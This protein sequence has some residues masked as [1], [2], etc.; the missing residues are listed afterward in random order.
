MSGVAG[1]RLLD[2]M[3]RI[4]ISWPRPSL[5]VVLLEGEH[6][7]GSAP[8][9][10]DALGNALLTCTELVVDLSSVQFID[11]STIHVIVRMKKEADSKGCSFRLVLDRSANIE[12]TL[13]ICGVLGSLN[14]VTTLDAALS[15]TR[16]SEM[17]ADRTT[18]SRT[19][20]GQPKRG[21]AAPRS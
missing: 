2:T 13:E 6:D 9:L 17:Q 18:A 20:S 7:M 21:S 3:P 16:L 4:S 11:S 15:E 10:E 12:R 8:E 5:A 14:R 1:I 19:L